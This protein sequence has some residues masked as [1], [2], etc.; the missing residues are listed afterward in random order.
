MSR[1]LIIFGLL[2]VALGLLWPIIGRLGIGRLPGDIMVERPNFRLY[3]PLTT[4]LV[5]SVALSV[6]L[7]LFHR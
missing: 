1:T 6:M 7:R 4:S 5:V 3:I 2:V